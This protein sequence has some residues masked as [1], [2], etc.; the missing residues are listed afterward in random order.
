MI[1]TG[2]KP[3]RSEVSPLPHETAQGEALLG[4]WLKA[5]LAS[6]FDETLREQPSPEMLELLRRPDA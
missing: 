1:N 2:K 3:D 6:R 5:N 4:V